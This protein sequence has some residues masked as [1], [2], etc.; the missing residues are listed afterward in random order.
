MIHRLL[1]A[2]ILAV[3]AAVTFA[4]AAAAQQGP[5]PNYSAARDA[6]Y[7]NIPSDSPYYGTWLDRDRDG[8]GCES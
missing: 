3:A 5:F 1:P 2:A 6:G 4:G 8:V 7:V